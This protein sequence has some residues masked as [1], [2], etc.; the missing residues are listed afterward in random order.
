MKQEESNPLREEARRILSRMADLV[1]DK[2]K[3]QQF[4]T[5]AM[6]MSRR[7][8]ASFESHP[9]GAAFRVGWVAMASY[10]AAVGYWRGYKDAK[11]HYAVLGAT[12]RTPRGREQV[13]CAVEQMLEKNIEMSTE[14]ICDRLD[15]L[16]REQVDGHRFAAA[17]DTSSGGK[18]KTIRVGQIYHRR[19]A[20]MHK[21]PCIKMM[22]S[23]L[24]VRIRRE[25]RAQAWME[26]S[27][28]AFT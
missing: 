6:E 16:D 26:K 18:Q 3:L 17:F 9:D 11:A 22:I 10:F 13:R 24:R 19:W 1:A 15:T 12:D 2:E 8:L 23:R 5:L 28:K 7:I 25:R 14:A 21:E 20:R 27:E 4:E